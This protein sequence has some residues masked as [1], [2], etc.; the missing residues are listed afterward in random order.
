MLDKMERR[1]A[2][3]LISVIVAA[4]GWVA[5]TLIIYWPIWK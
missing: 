2:I 1:R 5:I 3:I 4:L